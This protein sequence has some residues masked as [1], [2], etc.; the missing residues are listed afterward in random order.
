MRVWYIDT[1]A[2]AKLVAVENESKVLREW[3]LSS[4]KL[5]WHAIWYEPSCFVW[6]GVEH[7]N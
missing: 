6:C 5:W 2:L 1:S 4:P 3:L 7:Q